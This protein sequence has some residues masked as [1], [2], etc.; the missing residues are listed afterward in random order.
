MKRLILFALAGLFAF[1]ASA[2]RHTDRRN[3]YPKANERYRYNERDALNRRI[4][5]INRD[6][7]MQ[8]RYVRDNPH[9][10]RREKNRRI[11]ILEEDRRASLIRCRENFA[12]NHD[13][14]SG[15]N[16]NWRRY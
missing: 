11:R 16:R 10:R 5:H 9:L 7:D 13:D 12:R 1:S 8:I 15:R 4:D 3:D 14:Y 2:Q 6:Y